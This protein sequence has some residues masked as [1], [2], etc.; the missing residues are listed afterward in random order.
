ME[1]TPIR[2]LMVVGQMNRA[3]IEN[4]LMELYREIDRTKVQFDFYTFHREAGQFDEEIRSLGGRVYYND[5]ISVK[6]ILTLPKRIEAFCRANPE[7]KIIH[8]HMNQWCGLILKG[9]KAAGV[10]LRISH[11]HTSVVARS[12]KNRLKDLVKLP[13]N[14]HANYKIA[15]SDKAGKW[16]YGEKAVARGE[17]HFWKNTIRHEAFAFSEELRAEKRAELGLGDSFALIHVGNLRYP[18]NHPYL[19]RVFA[20]VLKL[21]PNSKL[22]CIGNDEGGGEIKQL[23]KD[24]GIFEQIL[25]LGS[26]ADVPELLQAGDVFVFPSFYEGFPCS[27]LEAQA[28]GLPCVV[29]DRITKEILVTPLVEM[30]SI[31]EEPSAWAKRV[32]ERREEC[33]VQ[34]GEMI[35]QAGYSLTDFVLQTQEFYLS[36]MKRINDERE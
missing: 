11:S 16:L 9:A 33:R 25:F 5:A 8:A 13:T 34:T 6:N 22:L 35:A 4:L 20:E 15:V 17:V 12:W 1:H 36:E 2:V 28:A 18:K 14:S 19:L 32:L 29:S 30:R 21:H 23:A 10:P 31:D 7:Y 24:I 26:R 3:G 27:V